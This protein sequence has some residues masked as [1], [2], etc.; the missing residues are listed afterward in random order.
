MND[1]VPFGEFSIIFSGDFAQLSP[2]CKAKIS[3]VDYANESDIEKDG[4]LLYR[5]IEY[6]VILT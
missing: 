2:V 4:K 1:N 3:Y 6:A 5:N